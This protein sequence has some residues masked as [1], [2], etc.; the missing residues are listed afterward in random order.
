[1]E[2]IILAGGL[3]TRLR[4]YTD[5][6]PKPLLPLGGTP[7]LEIIL[8]QLAAA[9]VDRVTLALHYRAEVIQA[10]VGDGSRFGLQ[11]E[12]SV[13]DRLLGTA[14]PLG[15]IERPRDACLVLN[16]DLLTNLDYRDLMARHRSRGAPATVVLFPYRTEVPFGVI[17]VD[18]QGDVAAFREKPSVEASIN[19]GIYVLEPLVWDKVPP[20]EYLEMSELIVRALAKGRT[21]ATYRHAGDWL[22]V[23]TVESFRRG[24]EVFRAQRDHYLP[25]DGS[26]PP[27]GASPAGGARDM[28]V[29]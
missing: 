21:V 4:P 8:R 2:A 28:V 9:G 12:H 13:A 1:M 3:G 20:G 24:D 5:V 10:H 6:I 7:I 14:G 17:D 19:A 22:D 29:A 26:T 23:G 11:V 25:A 16:A 15:L 18:N 27:D